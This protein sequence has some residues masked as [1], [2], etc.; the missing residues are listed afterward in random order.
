MKI[1]EVMK[2]LKLIEKKMQAN[3][4]KISKY[5]A[6]V[7]TERPTFPTEN[8]Q[9]KEVTSLIQANIDLTTEY[10]RK[11]CLINKTN[12]LVNVEI[13]GKNYT[14][15]ELLLLKR[16]LANEMIQTYNSLSDHQAQMRLRNAPAID[17]KP[18]QVVRM[19]EEKTRN[20]GMAFW[21][22]LYHTIDSRLEVVNAMTDIIE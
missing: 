4:E 15:S 2:D 1:I 21:Q 13:E 16:K 14:I 22:E 5:S 18:A 20:E 9:R 10:I 11:K 8:D 3:R 7:S 17:G 19:Y 6:I 12:D